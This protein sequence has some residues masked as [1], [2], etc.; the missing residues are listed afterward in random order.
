MIDHLLSLFAPHL[1][2]SC[3]AEGTLFCDN[4]KSYIIK[5]SLKKCWV[6]GGGNRSPLCASCAKVFR[7][8]YIIG[9]RK[10]GLALLVDGYKFHYRRFTS[11][12]LASLIEEQ[13][14][15][16]LSVIVPVPTAPSHVRQR[17][18]D[19][20]LLLARALSKATQWPVKQVLDSRALYTQHFS[21]RA[22]RYRQAREMFASNTQVD[23]RKT[24]L[25]L[26]DILTTG[27]TAL[28]AGRALHEAGARVIDLAVIARQP[29]D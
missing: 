24:Y 12:V 16:E 20:T 10:G 11:K 21:S 26:D 28:A 13:L 17:G 27:A 18:F 3:G 4:C 22:A 2:S 14:Q 7:R 25:L 29:L 1:C 8:I 6:C 9:E 5:A 23:S 15:S 19:H